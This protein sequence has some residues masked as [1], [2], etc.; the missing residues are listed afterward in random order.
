MAIDPVQQVNDLLKGFTREQFARALQGTPFE[1]DPAAYNLGGFILENNPYLPLDQ[2]IVP[3]LTTT[4]ISGQLHKFSSSDPWN[5]A[6][7]GRIKSPAEDPDTWY[8]STQ[9]RPPDMPLSDPP[10]ELD[11]RN[12]VKCIELEYG[13]EVDGG[14]PDGRPKPKAPHIIICYAGGNGA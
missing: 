7:N 2:I 1:S 12:V 14:T 5:L 13:P 4:R 11:A 3:A 6:K 9:R 10:R 8:F